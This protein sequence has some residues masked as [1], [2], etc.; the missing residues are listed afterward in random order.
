MLSSDSKHKVA[1]LALLS[2]VRVCRARQPKRFVLGVDSQF[3]DGLLLE[4]CVLLDLTDVVVSLIRGQLGR[5][6]R[7]VHL[8]VSQPTHFVWLVG[9]NR[10]RLVLCLQNRSGLSVFASHCAFIKENRWIAPLLG[11]K[12]PLGLRV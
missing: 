5:F 11:A 2:C 7:K 10:D 4:I 9:Q 12:F 1:E 8:L 6:A 3:I